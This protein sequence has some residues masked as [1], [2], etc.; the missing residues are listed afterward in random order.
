MRRE[1][2]RRR[3][4]EKG[5]VFLPGRH[6]LVTVWPGGRGRLTGS[7]SF[8]HQ[9]LSVTDSNSCSGNSCLLCSN[10]QGLI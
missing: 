1:G 5:E 6:A 7:Y 10:F 8:L 9:L 4:S 3:V 2:L